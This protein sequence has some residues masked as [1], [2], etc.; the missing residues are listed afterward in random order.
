MQVVGNASFV[1][2]GAVGTDFEGNQIALA[3]KDNICWWFDK[4]S[5]YFSFQ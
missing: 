2:I 1:M 4:P 3:A 5:F